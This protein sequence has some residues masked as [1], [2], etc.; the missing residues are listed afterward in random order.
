MNIE[1]LTDRIGQ[2]IDRVEN[3]LTMQMN[4]LMP[5]A[6]RADAARAGLADI[7]KDLIGIY[8]DMGGTYGADSPVSKSFDNA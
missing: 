6:M 4:H 7:R 8:T 1:D 3:H 5:T 2:L